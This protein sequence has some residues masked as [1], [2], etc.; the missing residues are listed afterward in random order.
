MVVPLDLIVTSVYPDMMQA[1]FFRVREQFAPAFN[2]RQPACL[3]V[4]RVHGYSRQRASAL[5]YWPR[6]R[7]GGPALTRAAP[8][9][10]TRFLPKKIG[11]Q[12]DINANRPRGHCGGEFVPL[13]KSAFVPDHGLK[14]WVQVGPRTLV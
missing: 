6:S 7:A 1:R 12:I 4:V 3:R 2:P 13:K 11:G 14:V 8:S 9:L 10:T 5:M